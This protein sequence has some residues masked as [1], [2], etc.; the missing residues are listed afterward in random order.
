MTETKTNPR[1]ERGATRIIVPHKEGEISFIPPSQGPHNYQT[2]GKGIVARNLE[3]PN[4]DYTASLLH[5]TYCSD[6]QNEPEFKEVRGTM[7]DRWL[8]VFNRNLW[9]SEGVF[10]VYDPE[11]K[12]L[13][14]KLDAGELEKQLSASPAG[15]PVYYSADARIRF[16]PKDSYRLG[17]HT[18]RS[19]GKDGFI[20]ASYGQEGAEKL[21][22][23]ADSKHFK[24]KPRTWGVN[25]DKGDKPVQRV[26]S[27]ISLWDVG[28]SWLYVGGNWGG[29]DVYGCAFGVSE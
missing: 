21:A 19:L 15:S 1:I 28:G 27:L 5:A 26:A 17:D 10:V 6:A 13:S 24:L 2:V 8:W 4:G 20:V 11:A 14:E 25:V 23:I 12:G 7:K 16:A 22:E 29:S 18:P 9:T 3:V